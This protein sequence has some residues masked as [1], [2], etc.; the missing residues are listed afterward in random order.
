M[1][2]KATAQERAIQFILAFWKYTDDAPVIVEQATIERDFGWMFHWQSRLAIEVDKSRRLLGNGTQSSHR[3]CLESAENKAFR[4]C[5]P[6]MGWSVPIKWVVAFITIN[7]I[8]GFMHI[9]YGMALEYR[10]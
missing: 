1:L 6:P 4:R 8:N 3:I 9:S 5:F 7:E 10:P 2:D